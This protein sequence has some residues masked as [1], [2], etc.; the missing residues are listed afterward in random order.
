[1]HIVV[2]GATGHIGTFLVPRLVNRGH[3]VTALSRGNRQPYQA[4]GAWR[5]V[6]RLQVDRAQE[7]T[8]GT[9]GKRVAALKPDAVI[10][11]MCFTAASARQLVEALR[12]QVE[13]LLVC[14]TIWVHGPSVQV[15]TS[16]DA[17]RHPFGDYGVNKNAMERY[18]LQQS[19]L[20]GVPATVIHP[21]HIVGAGWIPL[22]PQGNFNPK[23]YSRIAAGEELTL[24][25]FGLETVHHVHADDVAQVFQLAIENWAAAVGE[26]YHAVS[27]AALSLR[28]YAEAA[29]G[30]F[31]HEPK[32]SFMPYEAWKETVSS[33]DASATYDHIAHSPNCSIAKAQRLLG[34]KPRYTSLE[35]VKESVD[36]LVAH[37]QVTVPVSNQG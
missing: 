16:E 14:G 34:Y 20:G 8:Q 28:G 2:I 1:M 30:W 31:G 32:L 23:I 35:A 9:F 3:R 26:S 18:L 37:G 6:T 19:H 25:N 4:H 11:L 29:Y 13:H 10:D 27:P 7:D 36:W 33:D 15:P 21:G 17:V 12:G 24:A 5:Q 22:N